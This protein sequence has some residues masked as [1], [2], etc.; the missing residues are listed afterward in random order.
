MGFKGKLTGRNLLKAANEQMKEAFEMQIRMA[1]A[2]S[3]P[4]KS[5]ED[6]LNM[7]LNEFKKYLAEFNE[8]YNLEEE[9]AFLEQK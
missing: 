5:Y 1:S 8:F 6:I 9:T 3:D 7:P 2:D 4:H